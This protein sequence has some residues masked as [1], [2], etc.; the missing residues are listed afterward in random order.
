MNKTLFFTTF[1]AIIIPILL[2][3]VIY[4]QP[5]GVK[6]LAGLVLDYQLTSFSIS[7]LRQLINPLVL[8]KRVLLYFRRIRNL[9]IKYETAT[10]D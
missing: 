2:N 5:Y 1:N 8:I 9:I 7:F 4:Q 10:I 6:G 3:V